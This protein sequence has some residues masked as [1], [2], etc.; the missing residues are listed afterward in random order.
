[1][2]VS[3]FRTFILRAAR[4][5]R[6]VDRALE[7]IRRA[8]S[9]VEQAAPDENSPT[10]VAVPS[11]LAPDFATLDAQESSGAASTDTDEA[12]RLIQARLD[13]MSARLDA[14]R[15]QTPVEAPRKPRPQSPRSAT[16]APLEPRVTRREI[17]GLGERDERLEESRDL[18]APEQLLHRSALRPPRV[19]T[20]FEGLD[21]T[22]HTPAQHTHWDF[23]DG[24]LG[25]RLTG[26]FQDLRLATLLEVLQQERRIG[27]LML[28]RAG[29]RTLEVE[30]R[31]GNVTAVRLDGV[32]ADGVAALREAF[33]W[34]SAEFVF[35]KSNH[36]R[37]SDAPPRSIQG[38]MLEAL[39][40][41]DED[42]RTG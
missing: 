37:P 9:E 26:T 29:E 10:K 27:I 25:P 14:L 13:R 7:P 28:L 11:P 21:D 38:V 6:A 39:Q 40:K 15:D 1:M 3:L 22:P 42:A 23:P 24:G 41:N 19:P 5:L 4:G 16:R 2:A 31:H 30:V 34:P 18:E 20:G 12:L 36:A 17:R 32:E 33:R 8:A 35:L